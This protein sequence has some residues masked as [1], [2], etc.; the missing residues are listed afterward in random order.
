M[1]ARKAR[2][3][4]NALR[5]YLAGTL[6]T[7]KS[8]NTIGGNTSA[9]PRSGCRK[10]KNIGNRKHPLTFAIAIALEELLSGSILERAKM[11]ADK[12]NAPI[13]ANSVG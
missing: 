11:L 6:A 13:F 7:Y 5:K 10:I 4:I 12:T 3:A 2:R 1:T 8:E 9:D